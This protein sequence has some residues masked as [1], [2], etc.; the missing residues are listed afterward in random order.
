MVECMPQP[1]NPNGEKPAELQITQN[2]LQMRLEPYHGVTRLRIQ[3]G[4]LPLAG[5]MH[6]GP[7]CFSLL[8]E[9]LS[10]MSIYHR[11]LLSRN[12]S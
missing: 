4:L 9:P 3:P 12:D 7:G 11:G 8:D 10:L 5:V 6:L 1:G 2:N